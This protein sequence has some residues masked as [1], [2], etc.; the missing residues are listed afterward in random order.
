MTRRTAR[1]AGVEISYREAGTGSPV[2]LVHGWPQTGECWRGV[3]PALAERHR[4][5]VPDLPGFGRS[6]PP[7]AYDAAAL[8]R[9][10]VAFLQAV[11]APRASVV[12]HDWG[13]SL[14]F[15]LATHHAEALD[16]FVVVNAPFRK[17]DLWRGWHF[18]FL[19]L[20]LVPELAWTLAGD[21]WI[22]VVHRRASADAGVFDDAALRPYREAFRSWER[23]R[24]SLGY[25]RTVTRAT[26][27]RMLRRRLPLPLSGDGSKASRPR[28]VETPAM[29]VWGMRDPALP[30]HLL[31]GIARDIPH[32]RIERLEGCGHFVP[33]ECPEALAALLLDFLA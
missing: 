27:V 33:D 18:L 3:V 1:A 28:K 31:E 6:A 24:S 20:P 9:I 11:G 29:I 23:R 15:R 8:A 12:G 14:T 25:Y 22:D 5:I 17:L 13:G 10:V 4:V 7:P 30:P 21:R 19:N 26:L 16:R 2:M 32:A